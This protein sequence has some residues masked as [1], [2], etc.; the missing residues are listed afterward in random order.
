MR[1][2]LILALTIL[3]TDCR[4]VQAQLWQPN[5][6]CE[7]QCRSTLAQ[8]S[9]GSRKIMTTALK[10]AAPY[11]IETPARRKADIK[12]EYAFLGGEKCWDHYYRCA[13]T[14]RP[15]RRCIDACQSTFARC[16][17]AG[18]R[19]VRQGVQELKNLKIGSPEWQAADAKGDT[20]TGKCLENNRSCQAKCA[21]P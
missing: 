20:E 1:R 2:V 12:F 8:C 21:N 5:A 17:A 13:G 9:A 15:P 14:C 18:E 19:L 16:F 4:P 3:A 11:R 10:E 7:G 6:K